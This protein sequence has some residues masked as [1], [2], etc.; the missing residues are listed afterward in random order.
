MEDFT[1]PVWP[2]LRFEIVQPCA[3]LH[4]LG[5]RPPKEELARPNLTH[6]ITNY[7][8]GDGPRA[9]YSQICLLGGKNTDT[10]ISSPQLMAY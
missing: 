3:K 7:V 2:G 4:Q 6:Q 1:R 5:E 8:L 10:F 9:D